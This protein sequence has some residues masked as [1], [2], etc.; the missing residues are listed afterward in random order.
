[1]FAL[2][3]EVLVFAVHYKITLARRLSQP[4]TVENI[5]NTSAVSDDPGL[6]QGVG[7]QADTRALHPEHVS[8]ELLGQR[9]SFRI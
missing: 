5:D 2:S 7:D 9:Q 4:V 3:V 1:M 8:E 6:L